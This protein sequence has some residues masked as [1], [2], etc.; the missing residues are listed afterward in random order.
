MI[1]GIIFC[2]LFLIVAAAF[3]FL[4]ATAPNWILGVIA[5]L[6]ALVMLGYAYDAGRYA[7][8]RR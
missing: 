3:V 8:Q 5:L 6:G 7:Y 4:V 2:V 1:G